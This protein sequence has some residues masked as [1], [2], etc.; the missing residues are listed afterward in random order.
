MGMLEYIGYIFNMV[1]TYTQ[2]TVKPGSTD[3]CLDVDYEDFSHVLKLVDSPEEREREIGKGVA[4]AR[5]WI[6]VVTDKRSD[7]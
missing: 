5:Q 4:N 6:N 1:L 7:R 2:D 3:I